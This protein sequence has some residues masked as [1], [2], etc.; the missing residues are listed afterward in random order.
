MLAVGQ[1]GSPDQQP[2]AG[3]QERWHAVGAD[4]SRARI[5]PRGHGGPCAV[6][7]TR[8]SAATTARS[9]TPYS[10]FA[11][12][13]PAADQ[14]YSPDAPTLLTALPSAST[15]LQLSQRT[16]R[17]DSYY[18]Y[19]VRAS[20]PRLIQG[21][22]F[23]PHIRWSAGFIGRA[24]WTGAEPSHSRTPGPIR[25]RAEAPPSAGGGCAWCGRNSRR[26]PGLPPN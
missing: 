13:A 18:R 15:R 22:S 24:G 5:P 19:G 9:D 16:N 1:G 8:I 10:R 26:M 11:C 7:V 4:L 17:T 23:T 25:S 6:A 21:N 2:E 3:Q 20:L 14:L 12:Y